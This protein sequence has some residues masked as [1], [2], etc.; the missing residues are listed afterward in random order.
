MLMGRRWSFIG[1]AWS[2]NY[3]VGNIFQ[4]MQ[5][6]GRQVGLSSFT[7]QYPVTKYDDI[8]NY[9]LNC[10]PQTNTYTGPLEF[11]Y[12]DFFLDK[13]GSIRLMNHQ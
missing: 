8:A 1:V 13:S 2:H 6:N 4:G 12:F 11:D 7:Y 10:N 3:I 9:W 5:V